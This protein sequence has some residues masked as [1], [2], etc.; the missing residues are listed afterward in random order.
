M[1]YARSEVKSIQLSNPL[2]LYPWNSFIRILKSILPKIKS[3]Y[4]CMLQI[5]QFVI[6]KLCNG[7]N[8][9]TGTWSIILSNISSVWKWS[10]NRNSANLLFIRGRSL[11]IHLGNFPICDDAQASVKCILDWEFLTWD[12][13]SCSGARITQQLVQEGECQTNQKCH[14]LLILL[15]GMFCDACNMSRAEHTMEL[16]ARSS[17][18]LQQTG[19]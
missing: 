18:T 11:N 2:P 6:A 13:V 16:G 15:L 1:H 19:I 12:V 7:H 4:R 9:S 3:T 10:Y 14:V 8:T 17:D 5:G